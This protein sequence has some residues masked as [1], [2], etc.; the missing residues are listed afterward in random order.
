MPVTMKDIARD[1]GVSVITVSK[2]LRNHE[3]ISEPTRQRVLRRVKEL[4]YQPNRAAR[5]LVTGRSF[6]I[7]L[8]VPDL[9]HPFFGEIARAISR[10]IRARDYG[11]I[12]AASEDDP[13]I[14]AREIEGLIAR[15]VDGIVLASVQISAASG[16]FA[17]LAQ[18]KMPYV[19]IDRNFP[20]LEANYVGV[21][22]AAIGRMAAEHLVDR[23]C[24]RIAHLRGPAVSTGVGRLRGYRQALKKRGI[25]VPPEY[26]VDLK[27]GDS[28][29]EENGF[30]G[31]QRLL[32]L[33]AVPDG[34]FCYNDEV[35]IGA[36]RAILKADLRVPD[37]IA[38]IG[39]DNI[40]FA[41]LLR[42]PLS[43]ID[44]KSDQIGA[45]AAQLA[46]KLIESRE[47]LPPR[48]IVLPIELI[49]RD[50][51]QTRRVPRMD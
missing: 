19:L 18:S 32:G 29:S 9:Q 13:A 22:D 16:V 8:V 3:D 4:N 48:Q 28:Q 44:Q 33:R 7:G 27:G 46:L 37:D 31:M 42:V 24:L 34:V 10:S 1:L 47:S 36:L 49:A 39:V 12:I 17:R 45:Q 26:V 35:A 23:G 11:L 25:P 50:S 40:R 5:S 43:S 2:A 30:K 14:E 15:Q 21:D 41:D 51:T 38:V 6:T 20:G